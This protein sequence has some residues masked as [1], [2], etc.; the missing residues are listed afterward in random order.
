MAADRP[1][2]AT[3]APAGSC[4]SALHAA[5]Q[6]RERLPRRLLGRWPRSTAELRRRVR[7]HRDGGRTSSIEA[8]R[9][10]RSAGRTGRARLPA[11]CAPRRERGRCPIV[12]PGGGG[13]SSGSSSTCRS[14]DGH[15]IRGRRCRRSARARASSA[16]RTCRAARRR[17]SMKPISVR[18][19]SGSTASA[20]NVPASTMPADVITAPVTARPR[21]MPSRVPWRVRLL[22]HARHQEDVVVDAQRD[23]EDEREQRQRRVDAREAEDVSKKN[24]AD[25]ERRREGQ[26]DRRRSAAA[27][28]SSA[29]SS[30][31]RISEHDDE[32][33]RDDHLVV[34]RGGRRAGRRTPRVGPP[35]ST[36]V[37]AR[38]LGGLAQVRDQ[39]ERLGRVRV[40]A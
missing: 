8:M 7:S 6:G 12:M 19:T 40:G 24:D 23:E 35:T 33:D 5:E 31:A 2:R 37:A 39:V 10:A 16:R 18:K 14:R 3:R 30:S 17:R 36:S 13:G 20:E 9:G 15:Q 21:S 22:P 26:D 32:R 25:A 11:P 27:G 29:R 4:A 34:A 28:A 38:P 1:S